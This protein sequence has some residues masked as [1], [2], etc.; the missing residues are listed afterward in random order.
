MA[1]LSYHFKIILRQR[2]AT[3]LYLLL[4][5]TAA[6]SQTPVANRVKGVA[7]SLSPDA[8]VI[9]KYTDNHRHCI[10]Y[11]KNHRVFCFDV[12]TNQQQEVSIANTSYAHVLST[13][14]SP[15]G[16]FFFIA[17]DKGDL[18]T[19]YLDD[20]Q[21]LWRY[22]SRTKRS[23]KVGQGYA[24]ERHKESIVIRRASRCINPTAPLSHQRWMGRKHHFDLYGKVIWAEDEYEIKR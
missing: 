15:D 6:H 21:E 3:L 24:I 11:L 10:Y 17:I 8:K 9:A 5:L 20:G 2:L 12:M 22:D 16:N 23:D 7:K 13:W 1:F 4:M 19:F 14:L 18:A